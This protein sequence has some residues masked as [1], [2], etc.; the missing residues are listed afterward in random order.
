M[1]LL[2][3]TRRTPDVQAAREALHRALKLLDTPNDPLA[4]EDARRAAQAAADAVPY[5]WEARHCTEY[6]RNADEETC[7]KPTCTR[8]AAYKAGDP[9]PPTGW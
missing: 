2:P 5:R 1:P 6:R 9:M 8:C 3:P 7:R 4:L